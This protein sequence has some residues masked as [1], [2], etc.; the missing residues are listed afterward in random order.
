MLKAYIQ[1][2]QTTKVITENVI[3]FFIKVVFTC[4]WLMLVIR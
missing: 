3:Q 1:N 2:K 4:S